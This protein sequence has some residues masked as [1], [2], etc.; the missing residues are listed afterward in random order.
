MQQAGLRTCDWSLS[1]THVGTGKD[2]MDRDD[3]YGLH[4]RLETPALLRTLRSLGLDAAARWD[5]PPPTELLPHRIATHLAQAIGARLLDLRDADR[6]AWDRAL[7]LL[8][9]ALEAAGHPLRD[10]VPELPSAK[11]RQLLEVLPPARAAIASATSPRPDLPL[12]V[13]TLL[14]GSRHS[15][16]LVSQIEKELAS[17]DRADWLVSF[18]KF[19]GIRPLRD[20]LKQFT[21]QPTD[22]GKGP[23][24][25][26]ATTSYLGATDPEALAFLVGLPNTE[27][28]VSYDTHRTRLHAKAYV[29]HR[30][31]GFGAAYI[32]SANVS[33]VALD[34]GLEWTAR[35][36]QQE[37]PHLWRQVTAGFEM[38][39]EDG[40]E[41]EPLTAEGLACFESAVR[42][43]RGETQGGGPTRPF[44]DLRPYGFQQQILD[45]L[46]A[47]RASG[48]HRHLVIAATGTGKTLLAAFDY[49]RVCREAGGGRLRL[50]FLAHRKELLEQAWHSFQEVLHDRGFGELVV[51][52]GRAQRGDHLFCSVQSWRAQGLD[53]LDAAHFDYVVLDEAHHG[54]AASYQAILGHVQ[55]CILLGLTATPE[56]MDDSD[57]RADF[58]GSYSHE[59]RLPDA[60]EAR[61]LAPFHYYGIEDAEGI[62]LSRVAWQAG[63]YQQAELSNV[64]GASEIRAG[65]I[66]RQLCEH[67]AD[68]RR[69]RALGFCV[70]QAHAGFMAK[71]FNDRGIRSIA[72]T[73]ESP[74]ALRETAR[75]KLRERQVNVIFTVDLYN[76]G[77]DIPEVD[78]VLLLRPTE[79]LTVYLQQL[80]RGL[81][82]HPDK[83][84]LT[85]LDFIAPQSRQF[86]FAQRFRALSL[87]TSCDRPRIDKEIEQGFGWLPSGC[88]VRLTRKAQQHVLDNIRAQIGLNRPRLEHELRGLMQQLGRRPSLQEML[89]HLV[90][91]SPEDLLAKAPPSELLGLSPPIERRHTPGATRLHRGLRE[92][93]ACDDPELLAAL[94]QWLSQ[95]VDTA[96]EN[97]VLSAIALSL[98]W[99]HPRTSVQSVLDRLRAHAHWS[100]D[101][102]DVADWRLR[103]L[104]APPARRFEHLTGP[105]RLHA[106][107]TR[108]QIL[109][110]LG[111]QRFEVAGNFR[112][113]VLHVPARK[114]DVFFVT[115]DKDEKSFSPQT[116]F[117]DYALKPDEF[118]WQSQSRTTAKGETGRR[119]LHHAAQGYTPLLFLRRANERPDGLTES[120]CYLGPLAYLRH[121]G[122]AP[123][124]IVWRLQHQM[125][126]A[127]FEMAHR[128]AI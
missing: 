37:L 89:N 12:S 18:I 125:P 23:R 97:P 4:E 103:Q 123:I 51:D 81:R 39:W 5:D 93:A 9:E 30:R 121:S 95:S 61:L 115:I 47:E 35:I 107:Y 106:R 41:F 102:R 43:E 33:R 126:P 48:R 22:A 70:D 45:D 29:F 117:E 52:G 73:A 65:W 86:R 24:L 26:I 91:D 118:H 13:S 94:V 10:L 92:L 44:F 74:D 28:R 128:Q 38:H 110:A 62:D 55:P 7:R 83:A 79:S 60:V 120:F 3:W 14:T 84:Q 50:L 21:G 34:Q 99:G 72:L 75:Q 63:R 46:A 111:A 113:G 104:L 64:L 76:E 42:A 69:I 85:V 2:A 82:L 109:I 116:M 96:P 57:I 11:P 66:L 1:W 122:S 15:P 6:D 127:V 87:G 27:V 114:V 8:G 124:S 32:G 105:L 16:S 53:Q 78:T 19:S 68:P 100:E 56:R 40:A 119:Y 98:L 20:A 90:W 101:V 58:G 108:E 77:V 71:C 17:T 36:S 112:E 59:L 31:T 88:L 67:V 80:G 54:S 49:Q 25:R